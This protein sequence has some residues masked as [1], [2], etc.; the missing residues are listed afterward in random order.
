MKSFWRKIFKIVSGKVLNNN[1]IRHYKPSLIYSPEDLQASNFLIDLTSSVIKTAWG[2]ELNCGKKDLADSNLL[3]VY[4]GEH[5]RLLSAVVKFM[6]PSAVVEIGTWTGLGTLAISSGMSHGTV[7]TYDILDWDKMPMPTHFEKSDFV[8]GTINQV[9][10]DL[11]EDVFFENNK[12]ILNSADIIFLD[13]PKDGI[14]EYKMLSQIAKLDRKENKLLIL[15]D[16]RF[17]NMIDLW[18]SISSPKLDVSSFG[19]WSGTGF[20]D[21][22]KGLKVR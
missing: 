18:R 15:D 22:S 14:F 8:G 20:V 7:H 3:N 2:H 11:S 6:Q 1:D 5:Y 4:P 19:H 9:I 12:S 21:I 17:V 10:G 16:I 13:A